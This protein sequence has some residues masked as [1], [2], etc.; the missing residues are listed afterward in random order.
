MDGLHAIALKVLDE[1][2]YKT[3]DTLPPSKA[4]VD[5]GYAKTDL[6]NSDLWADATIVF[7][8]MTCFEDQVMNS[9]CIKLECMVADSCTCC[10]F[11]TPSHTSQVVGGIRLS[12]AEF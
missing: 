2:R 9:L 3:L 5:M 10:S 1:W 12:I 7:C 4:E 11:W 8:N 6:I